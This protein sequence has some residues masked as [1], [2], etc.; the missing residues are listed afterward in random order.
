MAAS[1]HG[2]WPDPILAPAHHALKKQSKKKPAARKQAAMGSL[3]VAELFA[4]VGGFRIG[5]E[6]AG[7][8]QVVWSNQWEPGRRKQHASEV[9]TARFG[10]EHH[11]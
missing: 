10:T 4:G 8:F 7:A 11:V 1:G 3:R 9:Y 2:W 6:R 5:L